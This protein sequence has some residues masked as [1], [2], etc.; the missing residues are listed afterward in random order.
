M[1]QAAKAVFDWDGGTRIGDSLET[2][3]CCGVVVGWA[4]VGSW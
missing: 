3:V 4:A 2:F 1:A